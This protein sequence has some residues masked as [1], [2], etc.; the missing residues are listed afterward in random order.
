MLGAGAG[1]L[2]LLAAARARGLFVIAVD[3]DPQAPGF[4]YAPR[5][6]I[7]PLED[8][9]ALERLAQAERVDGV[10][11]PA[12]DWTVATAA[13][14]AERLGLPHPLSADAA[15]VPSSKLRQRQRLA[16]AGIPQVRWKVVTDVDDEIGFPCVVRAPDRHEPRRLSPVRSRQELEPAVRGALRASRRRL[17]LVEELVEGPEVRVTAFSQAGAFGA[18]TV[19]D[20]LPDGL[21]WP[22]ERAE[23]AIALA[24]RAAAALGI[25]QGTTCTRIRFAADGPRLVA[26]GAR[27]GGMH[28]A[29]LCRAA[30]GVDLNAVALSSALGEALDAERLVPRPQAGGVCVRFLPPPAGGQAEGVAQAERV[31]GIEWVWVYRAPGRSGALLA[32]GRSA[33]DARA[34]ADRAAECIRF[35]TF[36]AEAVA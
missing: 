28:D 34:R 22:S 5:R 19:A 17:C 23:D 3:R 13:R 10:I 7:V 11:A 12:I 1:Q 8:D 9:S 29:E 24:E 33:A 27:L 4:R 26:L 30:L 31:E 16:E 15:L 32:T 36:D 14:I 18:L 35:S 2:G 20:R 6:A 21:V 25:A